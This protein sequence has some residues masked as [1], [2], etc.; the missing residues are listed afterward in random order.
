[1]G[2]T[3]ATMVRVG[4]VGGLATMGVCLIWIGATHQPQKIQKHFPPPLPHLAA[5]LP[6]M[7]ATGSLPAAP[8]ALIAPPAAEAKPKPPAATPRFLHYQGAIQSSLF[9]AASAQGVP[10]ALLGD[11]IR[12]FS[13]DVDFQR[14]IQPDDRFELMVEPAADK[15]SPAKLLFAKL[16]LSGKEMALYRYADQQ[17]NVDYYGPNGESARKALL[18]TPVDGARISS[19]FGRRFHPILHYT[20]QHKGIDFAVM[21]GTPG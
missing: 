7:T 9:E 1:M 4:F 5:P 17:G 12:V 11:M 14:D 8:A 10:A 18:R 16:T 13:Y 15:K 3:A 6:P 20:T 2:V 21:T 19:G